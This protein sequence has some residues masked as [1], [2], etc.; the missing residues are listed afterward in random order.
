MCIVQKHLPSKLNRACPKKGLH[1]NQKKVAGIPSKI[2]NWSSWWRQRKEA[3]LGKG[4]S[5]LPTCVGTSFWVLCKLTLNLPQ[6]SKIQPSPFLNL[7]W[8]GWSTSAS[9]HP[10]FH[11]SWQKRQRGSRVKDIE[12]GINSPYPSFFITPGQEDKKMTISPLHPELSN[13][14]LSCSSPSPS[15]SPPPDQED[16]EDGP[17]SLSSHLPQLLPRVHPQ[18]HR[19]LSAQPTSKVMCRSE[20]WIIFQDCKISKT[21]RLL[22]FLIRCLES[23]GK[24]I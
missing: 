5:P 1:K 16:R 11:P 8:W 12:D 10:L 7:P 6:D 4:F 18:I 2:W 21:E 13:P 3:E 14:T 24:S 15:I 22:T 20:L 19:A 23:P 9:L 17:S